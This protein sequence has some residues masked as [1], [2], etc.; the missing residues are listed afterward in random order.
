MVRLY[1]CMTESST[2]RALITLFIIIAILT[3]IVYFA[4]TPVTIQPARTVVWSNA[5]PASAGTVVRAVSPVQG[6]RSRSYSE[7]NY[8]SVRTNTTPGSTTTTY[9]YETY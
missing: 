7:T 6:S 9:Y 5:A 2:D 1:Y 4:R 3:V 8:S